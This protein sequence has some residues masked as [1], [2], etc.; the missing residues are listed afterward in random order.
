[1]SSERYGILFDLRRCTGCQTCQVSCKSENNVPLGVWRS[2]VKQIEKGRFPSATKSFLPVMCNNC[3][4]P[5]CVWV[6][7]TK[8]STR[9]PDGIVIIDAHRCIGCRHCM[10]ACPYGVRYINPFLG[11]A[12]KCDWCS[13][14]IDAGLVPACVRDCPT[15]AIIFG[16]LRDPQS[17][18]SRLI[19]EFPVNRLKVDM[20]T[21]PRVFYIGL[22][23]YALLEK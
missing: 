7:P 1:M 9:R 3:E 15:G 13:K 18:I 11:I 4:R 23:E 20:G 21:E 19:S 14:R 16:D 17:E 5:A 8:A 6:C 2:W 22:D 10:A 12:Q